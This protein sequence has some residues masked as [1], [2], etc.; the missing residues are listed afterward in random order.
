MTSSPCW[1]GEHEFES[2]RE[3]R[4]V[5]CRACGLA[6]NHPLPH[7]AG[8]K[9]SQY[10]TFDPAKMTPEY[11]ADKARSRGSYLGVLLSQASGGELLDVGSGEGFLLEGARKAG[12]SI[13]GVELN[14]GKATWTRDHLGM[15]V[16]TGT[17][18][19]ARFPEASFDVVTCFAVL[20]HVPDPLELLKE[21]L[22]ILK[23]GGLLMLAV[24]NIRGQFLQ[25]RLSWLTHITERWLQPEQHCWHFEPETLGQLVARAGFIGF[26]SFARPK[27]R[28]EMLKVRGLNLPKVLLRR[29]LFSITERMN[30]TPEMCAVARKG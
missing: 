17:L 13:H 14:A 30:L 23:P 18:Q 24:P 4:V 3:Q 1:C 16:R 15:D 7:H 28:H 9:A 5:R 21:C 22:R 12:F 19:D 2:V 6:R 26:K 8:T 27:F 10:G 20:E 11:R 25:M 29:I